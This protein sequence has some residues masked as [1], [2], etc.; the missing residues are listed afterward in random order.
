M[1]RSLILILLA[2]AVSGCARPMMMAY[3]HLDR[4]VGLCQQDE[5]LGKER[6]VTRTLVDEETTPNVLVNV[7]LVCQSF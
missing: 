4:P 2:L 1:R 6:F 5:L 3:T 7:T